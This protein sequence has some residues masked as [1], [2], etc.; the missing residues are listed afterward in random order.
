ME[1]VTAPTSPRDPSADQPLRPALLVLSPGGLETARKIKAGLPEAE[2]HTRL[3]RVEAGEV[4]F[5][6]TTAHLKQLF[7][8]GRPIL[9]LAASG[10]VIRAL[11]PLLSDKLSEPPVLALAE[12]GSAVVPLLGGH[13]GANDLARHL[14]DI[15]AGSAAITTAGDLRFG[16][17]LDSPPPGWL[18]GNPAD[19]K[20]V[21]AALLAGASLKLDGALPWLED[22]RI[23]LCDQAELTARAT[24]QLDVGDKQTLI[25]H[26]ATLALGVGC[27]RGCPSDELIDLVERSLAEANL[28]PQSIACVTSIDLKADETAVHDLAAHLGVPARFFPASDLEKERDRLATPSDVVFAEVGC[29]G[30]SEG[31]ALAA[32]GTDSDLILPKQKTSKATCALA[33]AASPLDPATIGQARGR[34]TIVGIGP[35]QD[36]WRTP[37]AS[38]FLAEAD[39]LVAYGLYLDILG[40]VIEGKTRHD[41]PLGDEEK[42][43]DYALK[44]AAEGKNVA[45]V[46]SGDAGI[47]AMATLVFELL[48]HYRDD[49]DWDAMRRVDIAV[50]PGISALQA[51]AARV[52][53][54]LAHD[55]CTISLSDLLT[56]WETIQQRLKACA[57]GD[58]IVAFYNPVSKRRR[59]QLAYAKEVLLGHRSGDTPVILAS[60]LGRPT[61]QVRHRTLASL[62]IDEVD[63]LTLVLVGNNQTRCV[64][65][66]KHK[67]DDRLWVYTPRGY[68]KKHDDVQAEIRAEQATNSQKELSQ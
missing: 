57:E 61:E 53:A 10:I 63:M 58:F 68:A 26:P 1:P 45:L 17:A 46:S 15:L 21:A 44:L 2:L 8:A 37:E 42:R 33:R 30:V 43:A 47:Y 20:P 59:T 18:L 16:V 51:A 50:T 55:F 49:A 38:R 35:G 39:H 6:E 31:A 54:P 64:P 62:D 36:G 12:D 65:R 9:A 25:Y 28:A 29:H 7:Q 22:S 66:T 34:L 3:D 5:E 52:G 40:P 32:A 23:N 41:F 14:A 48:D 60:N 13:H 4:V 27:E 11:A 56:P 67:S 19:A 24:E